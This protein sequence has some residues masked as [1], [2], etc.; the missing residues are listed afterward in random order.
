MPTRLKPSAVALPFAPLRSFPPFIRRH[1]PKI[2]SLPS[3]FFFSEL[4]VKSLTLSSDE[5]PYVL[6]ASRMLS[7]QHTVQAFHR[8]LNSNGPRESQQPRQPSLMPPITSRYDSHF[9]WALS[10]RYVSWMR[11]GPVYFIGLSFS[12]PVFCHGNFLLLSFRIF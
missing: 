3:P 12:R 9:D 7:M 8:Q 6:A 5:L 11:A 2:S 4:Q 1:A 10:D